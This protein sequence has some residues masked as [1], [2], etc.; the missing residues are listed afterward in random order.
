MPRQRVVGLT[1]CLKQ[2][3]H[4]L[5]RQADAGVLDADAQLHAVFVF[6][7][8]HGA[9]NDGAFAGEL[10]RVADQVGEDL[11]EPQRIT[12]QRQRRVAVNQAHQFQL[13]GVGGRGE[14]G[15]GVLQQVAQVERN[16]VEHQFAGLDLREVEDLVNDPQQAVGGFFDGAQVV[17]LARG[18]LAF[19]QQVRETENAVERRAD[20]VAHV[21]Q[22][23]GLDPARFQ[24]F[25]ARQV[26]LDVLDFNGFQILA[27]VFGGL[28]DAVLQF[29]LGILQGAG[30]AV[31]AG[32]QFIQLLAAEG[33]QAG[34][35]MTVLELGHGLLD[36]A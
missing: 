35:Q 15:Q 30:H 23:L 4:I 10:D 34:F 36:L 6:F 14:D 12:H 22:E 26:E 20:F 13:L 21:G 32:R 28:V 29:F 27:H 9:G 11:L 25:L 2:R 18:Q 31:D 24:G 8:K 17:E 5:V 7:F 16:M 19:L 3:A 33:R 1:E